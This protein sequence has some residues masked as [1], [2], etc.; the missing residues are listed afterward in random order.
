MAAAVIA[1][2][3]AA[4]GRSSH[5]TVAKGA[6]SFARRM[7]SRPNKITSPATSFGIMPAPGNDS[8]PTG[9]SPLSANTKRP[10][11]TKTPPAMWSLRRVTVS[12]FPSL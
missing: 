3:R 1:T 7:S 10:K 8:V 5:R 9:K 11:A 12:P 6:L 2:I 4:C